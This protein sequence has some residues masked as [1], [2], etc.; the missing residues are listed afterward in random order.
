MSKNKA[1][2]TIQAFMGVGVPTEYG[3]IPVTY[4]DGGRPVVMYVGGLHVSDVT[5]DQTGHGEVLPDLAKHA[6]ETVMDIVDH[7][8]EFR[9]QVLSQHLRE[10]DRAAKQSV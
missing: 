5:P 3:F 4:L 10:K 1:A 6:I 7:W 9:E 8:N 2:A